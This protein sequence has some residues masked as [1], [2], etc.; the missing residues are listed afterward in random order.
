MY[1]K[2]LIQPIV[3]EDVVASEEDGGEGEKEER[4]DVALEEAEAEAAVIVAV[5]VEVH[6]EVAAG[7][8]RRKEPGCQSLN[9]VVW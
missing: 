8:I 6:Q 7:G 2:W 9:L 4:A 5:T 3:V 1:S